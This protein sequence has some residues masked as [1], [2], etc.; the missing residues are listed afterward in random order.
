M[1]E[2]AAMRI[3]IADLITIGVVLGPDLAERVYLSLA[4]EPRTARGD[5]IDWL[6]ILEEIARQAPQDRYR[7][8]K[9]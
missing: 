5:R 1:L 6:V 4:A 8:Q 7:P 3:V 9:D 2:A